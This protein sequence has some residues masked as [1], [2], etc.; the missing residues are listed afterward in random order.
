PGGCSCAR[1]DADPSVSLPLRMPTFWWDVLGTPGRGATTGGSFLRRAR[2]LRPLADGRTG[3]DSPRWRIA[4]PLLIAQYAL[5]CEPTP[6]PWRP[7]PATGFAKA[8]DANLSR[9]SPAGYAGRCGRRRRDALDPDRRGLG[10]D[11]RAAGRP[12]H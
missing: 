9:P 11:C 6:A 3:S 8:P 10:R 12:I 4:S 5:P 1:W 2:R 7:R